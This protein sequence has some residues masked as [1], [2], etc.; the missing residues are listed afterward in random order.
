MDSPSSFEV[1]IQD[2]R[3]TVDPLL[4]AL[5][6]AKQF[7]KDLEGMIAPLAA[8]GS[9]AVQGCTRRVLVNWEQGMSDIVGLGEAI[10]LALQ[11]TVVQ[12]ENAEKLNQTTFTA[13]PGGIVGLETKPAQI[14][15]YI[16]APPA[17]GDGK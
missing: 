3:A 4:K 14:P 16:A 11:A 8:G 15:Q 5:F 6:V 13:P 12:Y 17:A 2:V 1:S 9:K 10:A 7:S